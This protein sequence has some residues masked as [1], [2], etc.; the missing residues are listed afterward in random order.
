[1]R[2]DTILIVDDEPLNR[3]L[4]EG[5]LNLLSYQSKSASN[6]VEALQ[7]LDESIDLVLLDVNMPEI[8]GF[9]VTRRIRVAEKF[10]DVPIIMVTALSSMQDR[11]AAV[12]AG[13]ND[14][15]CKPVDYTELRIRVASQ[16]RVKHGQN[17]IKNYHEELEMKVEER[18]LSL[19][20]ANA[21]LEQ[22][23]T[24]DA[25]TGLPNH[26]SLVDSLDRIIHDTC[27]SGSTCSV[28]FIDLD[29]FKNLNDSFGHAVGDT[30]L[31]EFGE[32]LGRVVGERGV[33]GRWGGEE[34][35]CILPDID[36]DEAIGIAEDVRRSVAQ[37]AFHIGTG[38]HMTCSIG[39][40]VAPFD[41]LDRST[42]AETAD[43]AM[44]VAKALGRNQVR[45]AADVDSGFG[46][47]NDSQPR[48]DVALEGLVEALMSLVHARDEVTGKRTKEVQHLS[49][50]F[51]QAMGLPPKEVQFVGLVG[52]LYDIG[53]VAIPDSILQKVGRLT[54]EEWVKMKMHP[55]IGAEVVGR[56]PNLRLAAPALRAHHE[57]WD[58]S[59]YP[60]GLAGDKIPV[61]SR[62]VAVCAAYSAMTGGRPH[63]KAM[64]PEAAVAEIRRNSGTQFAPEVVAVLG[65]VF[66]SV[67]RA[68]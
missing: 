4:L 26:R 30:V 5:M 41:G 11:L 32:I 60:D 27:V 21:R 54:D 24:T 67:S 2:K 45:S 53:K 33:C 17:A 46:G 56:V 9:E 44:Y 48:Q 20:E 50:Q 57:K 35:L 22:L 40:A 1:M 29:H 7:M 19:Q 15:I 34:F 59:G 62:I 39:V 38:G 47:L 18:T 42:I 43:K 66:P 6:G 65:L 58:G 52:K 68:A 10:S 12:E 63:Q 36:S 3:L 23:A 16:L 25:L 13:A 31:S 55:V 14:F 8:T 61:A 37:F 64:S 28:L 51:A 49:V